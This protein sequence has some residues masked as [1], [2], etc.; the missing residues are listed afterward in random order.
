TVSS[1]IFDVP[2]AWS[3]NIGMSGQIRKLLEYFPGFT[4]FELYVDD[5]RVQL[6][7]LD[8]HELVGTSG[9]E[10]KVSGRDDLKWLADVRIDN[11]RTFSEKT[12][13]DLTKT[14]L[15]EVNL[16]D[17]EIKTDN[18]ANRKAITGKSQVTPPPTSEEVQTEAGG[19]ANAERVVYKT[20]K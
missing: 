16:G 3:M 14:A 15:G 12:F 2:A 5:T 4:P 8:S 7:E 20:L 13:L 1:G 10:V 19:T 6:G 11:D 18:Y 9:T 17:R